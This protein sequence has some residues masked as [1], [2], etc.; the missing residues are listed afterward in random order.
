MEQNKRNL[1]IGVVA[2]LALAGIAFWF[3]NGSSSNGSTA[4][5][6][7]DDV[8]AA[9]A[10]EGPMGDVAQGNPDAPVTIYEYASLTCN[11][12]AAFHAN[13]YPQLKEQ[14]IDT[15]KV[16]YVLRA[17][18][19]D[20]AATAAVMLARCAGND[21]YYQFMDVLFEQQAQWAFTG[22]PAE[23]LENI[24]KQG[25]FSS[26]SFNACLQNEELFNHVRDVQVRGQEVHGVRSTPTFFV[27]GIKLEGNLPFEQLE[28][29]LLEQL[30]ES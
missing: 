9:L 30:G 13:T 2:L 15:G 21:R 8:L 27:N 20:P 6:A 1:A 16:R 7:S 19:F 4:E 25:G 18:P 5:S 10:V 24:A 29:V 14:Y 12:C 22:N 3:M 26:D 28:E 17:F 23:N 11:H